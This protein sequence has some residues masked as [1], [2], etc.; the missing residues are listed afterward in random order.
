M[1]FSWA[2]QFRKMWTRI[3]KGLKV[4]EF[5]ATQLD[6]FLGLF[7]WHDPSGCPAG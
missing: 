2:F 4:S 1:C 3:E 5:A 7:G 6:V